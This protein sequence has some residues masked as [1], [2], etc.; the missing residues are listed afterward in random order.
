MNVARTAAVRQSRPEDDYQ[1]Q[2]IP[3][4]WR[5]AKAGPIPV[6]VQSGTASTVVADSYAEV[7]DYYRDRAAAF[8]RRP[9]LPADDGPSDDSLF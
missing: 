1:A 9:K 5:I 8:R 3:L 7:S 2:S 6:Q 4:S